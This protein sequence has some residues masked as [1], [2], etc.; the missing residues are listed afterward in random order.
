[1]P[2]SVIRNSYLLLEAFH[3]LGRRLF[4][5]EWSRFELE[6]ID[7]PDPDATDAE[8]APY[9]EKVRQL[10]DELAAIDEEIRREIKDAKIAKLKE[11]RELAMEARGKAIDERML[12]PGASE[13]HHDSYAA[14]VRRRTT[15][16]TLVAALAD[17]KIVAFEPDS[18]VVPHFLWSGESR[19]FGFDIRLSLVRMPREQYR[20]RHLLAV[21]NDDEFDAWLQTVVPLVESEEQKLSPEVHCKMILKEIVREHKRGEPIPTTQ[22]MFELVKHEI[23]GLSR[24]KFEE[25]RVSVVPKE[26]RARGRRRGT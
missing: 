12:H 11:R 23:P 6:Q 17:K 20:R 14:N 25:I 22:D 21:V 24:R 4:A 1:M 10:D 13:G 8:H 5:H 9:A 2:V 26:W 7:V 19:F 16:D 15:M 18:I 3:L